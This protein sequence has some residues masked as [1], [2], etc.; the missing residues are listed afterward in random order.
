[1]WPASSPAPAPAC[2]GAPDAAPAVEKAVPRDL[3][4][5]L[6]ARSS[7]D[8]FFQ[9]LPV[10]AAAGACAAMLRARAT[11]PPTDV[12]PECIRLGSYAVVNRAAGWAAGTYR[13]CP[14]CQ[15]VHLVAGGDVAARAQAALTQPN[16]NCAAA[17]G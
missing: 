17:A 11:L 10:P 9:P 1:A 2:P 12:P 6:R 13:Y 7:G 15:A 16:V 4:D 5:V 8:V 3:A 14:A